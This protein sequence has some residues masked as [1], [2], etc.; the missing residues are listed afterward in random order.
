MADDLEQTIR[1]NAQGPAEAQGDNDV[2]N[3]PLCVNGRAMRNSRT[4]SQSAGCLK[5]PSD[6]LHHATDLRTKGIEHPL[7]ALDRHAVVL[8]PL[9]ARDLELVDAEAVGK[10]SLADSLSDPQRHQQLPYP[11]KVPQLFELPTPQT[12]VAF[13]FFLELLVKR[14]HG[15]HGPLDLLAAQPRLCQPLLLLLQSLRLLADSLNRLAVFGLTSACRGS[16]RES[17]DETWRTK[18]GVWQ[19][20]E[21]W[22][23]VAEELESVPHVLL[24]QGPDKSH[25][26]PHLLAD[27]ELLLP[28][29]GNAG[30]RPWLHE[31]LRV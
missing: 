5:L 11:V 14:H 10:L 15:V 30:V 6:L 12:L 2:T 25:E 23:P 16:R 22:A 3:R 13:D 4:A 26:P 28:G 1:E 31:P 20:L 24:R 7:G 18:T 19:S 29:Q 8:I 27:G 21:V 17:L 9:V